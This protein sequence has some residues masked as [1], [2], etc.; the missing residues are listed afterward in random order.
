MK[1]QLNDSLINSLIKEIKLIKENLNN[2]LYNYYNSF[3]SISSKKGIERKII[4]SVI[5]LIFKNNYDLFEQ[6]KENDKIINN[7]SND[8]TKIKNY[9]KKI[10]NKTAKGLEIKIDKEI[11]YYENKKASRNYYFY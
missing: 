8:L 4:N 3:N 11:Q 7:I 6:V 9:L 1:S 2:T 5:Y 10:V